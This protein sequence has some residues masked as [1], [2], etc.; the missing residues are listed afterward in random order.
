MVAVM[1]AV[2]CREQLCRSKVEGL[3]EGGVVG[4]EKVGADKGV[5]ERRYLLER[6]NGRE[7]RENGVSMC[8]MC[9]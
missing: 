3:P 4:V 6:A 1:V 2:G 7:D 5:G 9:M 8:I